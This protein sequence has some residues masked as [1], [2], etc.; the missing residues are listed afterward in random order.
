M[1][2]A[3]AP[4]AALDAAASAYARAAAEKGFLK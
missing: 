1:T 2:G 4:K 3:L